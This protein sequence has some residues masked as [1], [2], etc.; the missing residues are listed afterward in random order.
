MR[1]RQL[2]APPFGLYRY[3]VLVDEVAKSAGMD[4]LQ[5]EQLLERTQTAIKEGRLPSRDPE[6]GF[7][8]DP[9]SADFDSTPL[10]SRDDFNAWLRAEGAPYMAHGPSEA[11]GLSSEGVPY[12]V[13]DPAAPMVPPSSSIHS[14]KAKRRDILVP[15]IELAQGKC[16]DPKDTAEVFARLQVLAQEEHPPL[17]AA[18]Q[19]GLKYMRNGKAA[20]FTREALD[21]RLHPEKR[22][23]R[24]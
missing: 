12:R 24:R 13:H 18:T 23:K 3:D 17:L 9:T 14:T 8:L 6:T 16:S 1:L 21:R 22:Q 19:G 10:T 4:D 7:R 5:K 20:Y 11:L 15:V 2:L